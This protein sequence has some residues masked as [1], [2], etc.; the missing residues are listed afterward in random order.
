MAERVLVT[1]GTGF[2]G[3][4]LVQILQERN[5]DVTCLVRP[6][7]DVSELN[8][9]RVKLAEGDLEDPASLKGVAAG[10]DTVYHSACSV[11]HTFAHAGFSEE[12]FNRVN[13]EGSLNLAREAISSGVRKF[14]HLSSTAA[15]GTPAKVEVDETTACLPGTPYQVSKYRA[16]QALLELQR[17]G[18]LPLVIVRS[19]LVIGP[20]REKAEVKEMF[21]LIKKG[22]FPVLGWRMDQRKPLIYL[23]DLVQVLLLAAQKGR[24]GEIY[25]VTSG[26]PYTIKEL[27]STIARVM[28]R[29][30]SRVHIPYLPLYLTAGLI[31]LA[32]KVLPNPPPITRKR[33]KLFRADRLINIEK[34]KSEL[35]YRPRVSDLEEMM[36]IT[37]EWYKEND[38]I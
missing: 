26:R 18:G 28:G 6:S 34:A 9:W 30:R 17:E 15:M 5:Y 13:V 33:I 20:C 37:Y 19:C 32:A 21:K 38:L 10:M 22:I 24:N 27:T 14:V 4:R 7:S 35:G 23:D 16:E 2:V 3:R 1:G 11:Q 29:R 36:R 8:N 31:E 25:L 12:M